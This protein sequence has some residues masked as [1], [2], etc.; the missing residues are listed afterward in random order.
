MQMSNKDTDGNHA[1]HWRTQFTTIILYYTLNRMSKI[2][3]TDQEYGTT[4]TFIH[5]W[6][7]M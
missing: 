2:K 7:V 4:G 5:Y 3:S 6:L 1:S